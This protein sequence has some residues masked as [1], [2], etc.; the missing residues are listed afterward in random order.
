MRE[1]QRES[2][3][4]RVSNETREKEREGERQHA[5]ERM[6]VHVCV[7]VRVRV[8][9]RVHVQVRF[10]THGRT[11]SLDR[12]SAGAKAV[13]LTRFVDMMYVCV[14]ACPFGVYLVLHL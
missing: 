12:S 11:P 1:H 7:H 9:V 3:Q 4:D 8:R 13:R 6:R 10:T 14:R 2:Q 5:R